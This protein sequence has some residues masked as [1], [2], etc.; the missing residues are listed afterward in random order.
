MS[1]LRA[2]QFDPDIQINKTFD[3]LAGGISDVRS[4]LDRLERLKTAMFAEYHRMADEADALEIFTEAEA[5][6]AL[7]LETERQLADLRRRYD[8]P[9]FTAGK[10][11]RYTRDHIREITAILE[12]RRQ[13]PA[14]RKAA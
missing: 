4:S 8:L 10:F 14:M 5:A 3:D 13:R 11:V 9:H 12:V 6:T 1:E 2:R 7:K